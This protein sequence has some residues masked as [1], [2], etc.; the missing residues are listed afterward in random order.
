MSALI[1]LGGALA[2]FVIVSLI[3]WLR[4]RERSVTFESSIERFQHEMGV[5][6]P[7]DKPPREDEP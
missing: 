6:A 1:F 3:S 5:L 7:D 2:I 4:N